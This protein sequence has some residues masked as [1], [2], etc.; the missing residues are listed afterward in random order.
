MER[1]SHGGVDIGVERFANRSRFL[2]TIHYGDRFDG[3][4]K[5]FNEGFQREGAIQTDFD[6]PDL[7]ALSNQMVD[8]FV[9]DLGTGTHDNDYM[10]GFRMPVVLEKFVLS[11]NNA[12]EFIHMFLNNS[13]GVVIVPV[14]R[15]AMLEKD[16]GVLRRTF[17]GRTVGGE[18]ASAVGCN[19]FLVEHLA[20]VIKSDFLNL[21]HL[22]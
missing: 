19:E 21:L 22:V 5:S 10:L 20:H 12:G 18:G 7:F 4:R 6:Q 1:L 2:G 13:R 15:F 3:G 8:C 9:N 11:S 17:D 14:D 16:I